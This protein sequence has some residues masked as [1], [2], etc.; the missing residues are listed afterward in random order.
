MCDPGEEAP[1][2]CPY[3]ESGGVEVC[4]SSGT[5][6]GQC[7]CAEPGDASIP[8]AGPDSS[9]SVPSPA[10]VVVAHTA[11]G[12]PPV[13][14]CFATVSG[15]FEPSVAAIPPLPDSPSSAPAFPSIGSYPAVAA[16]TPGI[17]PGTIG[18]LPTIT[19]LSTISLVPFVVLASSTAND[20]NFAAG[21]GVNTADGGTRR[22][23]SSSSARTVRGRPGSADRVDNGRLIAGTDFIQLPTIPAGTLLDG[24]AYLW[25]LD[26]CLPG[27]VPAAT[28]RM[29]CGPSYDGGVGLSWLAELDTTTE[30]A[31]Q[32]SA[33]SS[34][35]AR[36]RSRTRRSRSP[37][38]AP[39]SS[40]IRPRAMA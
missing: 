32:A 25:T 4:N 38:G 2:A 3:P 1:C 31:P 39:R 14:I 11:P 23:A 8:D 27:A 40:F 7:L 33:C 5:A 35:I 12:A 6:F 28:Q 37:W 17:Y 36:R 9:S 26:G 16:G 22:T 34:P 15:T 30:P 24:K 18:A 13:R 19:D 20:V 29:T 10:R 21:A